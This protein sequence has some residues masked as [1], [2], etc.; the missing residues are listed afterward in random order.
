MCSWT[1]C[2]P[3]PLVITDLQAD[4]RFVGN[5]WIDRSDGLRFY[6]GV[7]LIASNGTAFGT[8]CVMDRRPHELDSAQVEALA[9]LAAQATALLELRARLNQ[10]DGAHRAR[11]RAEAALHAVS[12]AG[13][14][15]PG[16]RWRSM[17]GR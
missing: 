9:T 11:D 4:G 16:R 8:L 1:I 6:A 3:H 5:P 14:T 12:H 17:D 10:L 13:S 15:L 2:A 7:P